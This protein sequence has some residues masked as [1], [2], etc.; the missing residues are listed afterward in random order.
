MRS[1]LFFL[2]LLGCSRAVPPDPP[3]PCT[4][5]GAQDPIVFLDGGTP[6]PP[7][8]TT[9]EIAIEHPVACFQLIHA[10]VVR[11]FHTDAGVEGREWAD[12]LPALALNHPAIGTK[13]TVAVRGNMWQCQM[14]WDDSIESLSTDFLPEDLGG[15]MRL[16]PPTRQVGMG[17]HWPDP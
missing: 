3:R 2:L 5:G 8:W 6:V 9:V 16:V 7:G 4:A 14:W 13:L 1:A 10:R 17:T 11:T 15:T 12:D